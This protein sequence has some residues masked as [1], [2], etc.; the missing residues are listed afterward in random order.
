MSGK[1]QNKSHNTK[2]N[3]KYHHF[4]ICRTCKQRKRLADYPLQPHWRKYRPKDPHRY[5]ADC[6]ECTT[7]K[8]RAK[9]GAKTDP[10]F[11]PDRKPKPKKK[12]SQVEYQRQTRMETRIHVLQY[13][14]QKGCECCGERD[15]RLLEF[16]HRDPSKKKTTVSRLVGNG[17][18][19]TSG[20]LRNEILKCR[21]ICANCHRL[22][23]VTQQQYYSQPEVQ[24]ALGEIFDDYGI[25]PGGREGGSGG[26]E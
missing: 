23:T 2:E 17:M 19:W 16:D 18:S 5:L 4:K 7:K 14:A 6:K 13:L 8:R 20:V 21:V 3:S 9:N 22:H 10:N 12:F 25:E 15:P 24:T 1:T 26:D 11:K